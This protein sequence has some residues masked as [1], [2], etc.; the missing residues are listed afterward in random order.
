MEKLSKLQ[1]ALSRHPDITFAYLFGSQASGRTTRMSD[2][3]IAVY[4]HRSPDGEKRLEILGLLID[5]LKSDRVDLVILNTAPLPLQF[6]VLKN[7]QLL[8]D[9]APFLR[10][11]FESK[12]IVMYLDFSIFE[13]R[14]LERR[15]FRDQ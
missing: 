10:H 11:A 12:T 5:T 9:K 8:V 15:F 2:I 14:L 13:A 6:R 1:S 4:L 3:D 7:N